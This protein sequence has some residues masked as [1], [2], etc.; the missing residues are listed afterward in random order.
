MEPG[1]FSSEQIK[2]E[3]IALISKHPYYSD[4]FERKFQDKLSPSN[5]IFE[6]P[7]E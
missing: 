3:V 1:K 6:Q 2:N 4:K 5:Q 7:E